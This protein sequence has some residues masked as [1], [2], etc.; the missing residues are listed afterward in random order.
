M[1]NKEQMKEYMQKHRFC[2]LLERMKEQQV[3]CYSDECDRILDTLHHKDENHANN[4]L[5]NLLPVCGEHHLKIPHK[6][7]DHD[8]AM[9]T[10]PLN[11]PERAVTRLNKRFDTFLECYN[12]NII[13]I[14]I[15]NPKTNVKIHIIEISKRA[16]EILNKVGFSEIIGK[17]W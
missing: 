8:Y 4:R 3:K 6:I 17:D 9:S 11:E 15:Y 7:D 14:I 12:E 1:R 13:C 2:K 10:M 5:D 16:G